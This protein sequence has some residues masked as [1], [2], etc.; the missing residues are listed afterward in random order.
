MTQ[1]PA[2][3]YEELHW[4]T[5][6]IRNRCSVCHKVVF[7]DEAHAK[8]RAGLIRERAPET[9]MRAHFN[10]QCGHWHIKGRKR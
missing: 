5:G 6:K 1:L 7:R 4:Y 3:V 2:P 9:H 10:R 8:D